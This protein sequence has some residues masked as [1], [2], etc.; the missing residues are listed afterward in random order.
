MKLTINYKLRVV[1]LLPRT[2]HPRNPPSEQYQKLGK[3]VWWFYLHEC[4]TQVGS[5]LDELAMFFEEG[6]EEETQ[7]LNEVLLIILPIGV[8]QSDVCVQRQH[9]STKQSITSK[10][11][12]LFKQMC[13]V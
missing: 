13:F 6:A 3:P 9:L 11:S 10:K 12:P 2:S 8:G 5:L 7:V 1:A 4:L